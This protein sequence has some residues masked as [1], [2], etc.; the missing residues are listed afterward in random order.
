M[1][2]E[3]KGE[4]Q[5]FSYDIKIVYSMIFIDFVILNRK[6]KRNDVFVACGIIIIIIIIYGVYV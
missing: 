4:Q 3:K 6:S 1:I 5:L 2:E